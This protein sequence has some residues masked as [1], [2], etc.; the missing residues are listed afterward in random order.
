M[1]MVV[2]GEGWN[3]LSFEKGRGLG[4]AGIRMENPSVPGDWPG[5]L[6]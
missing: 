4:W 1:E 5:A 6:L 3:S 2:C